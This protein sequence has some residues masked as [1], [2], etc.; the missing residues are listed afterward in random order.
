MRRDE[1]HEGLKKIVVEYLRLDEDE[2]RDTSHLVD[3]LGADSLGLVELG[4][5]ISEGF[6]IPIPEP[7]EGLLVFRNM[8][9]HIWVQMRLAHASAGN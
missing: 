2:V 6:S 9:G 4:Y 5:R 8:V 7:T 1:I 3:D